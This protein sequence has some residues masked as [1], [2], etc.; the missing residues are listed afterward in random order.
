M[1][2]ISVEDGLPELEHYIEDGMPTWAAPHVRIR[3][4]TIAL[5]VDIGYYVPDNEMWFTVDHEWV[6]VTHWSPLDL[7]A[8]NT[9]IDND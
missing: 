6:G 2:W 8:P 3:N 9:D 1:E 4:S 7:D 5:D